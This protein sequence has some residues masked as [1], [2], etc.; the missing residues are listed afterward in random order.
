MSRIPSQYDPPRAASA[1]DLED[2]L[3]LVERVFR[4]SLDLG[5]TME[6]EF[7]L[8]F[9]PANAANLFIVRDGGRVVAHAGLLIRSIVA[10]PAC[11]P[12]SAGCIGAVCVDSDHRGRG[13][14]EAVTRAC[15][16]RARD[17][18]CHLALI[19]G[20][21]GIYARCGAGPVV[22]VRR[23]LVDRYKLDPPEAF[24][25]TIRLAAHSDIEPLCRLHQMDAPRYEWAPQPLGRLIEAAAHV[26]LRTWVAQRG[27]ELAA[28]LM[29]RPAPAVLQSRW[30]TAVLTQ[31]VG[32][33]ELFAPLAARALDA[34]RPKVLMVRRLPGQ[35]RL[36][37]QLT[38]FDHPVPAGAQMSALVLDGPGLLEAM[39]P[40]LAREP[41][42]AVQWQ[43]GGLCLRVQGDSIRL[44]DAPDVAAALFNGPSHW[45]RA[46]RQR[47][48]RAAMAALARILPVPI[49]DYGLD[50]I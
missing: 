26:G 11:R 41:E 19:S 31:F 32:R 29:I 37:P 17:A 43:G 33:V 40:R 18:G 44:A 49:P 39:A 23:F 45:P 14:G 15:I 2:L 4:T 10:D 5:P 25:G 46:M 16:A 1:D 21:G 22:P 42:A 9:S 36:E 6:L 20:V 24:A 50:Y 27:G 47:P 38:R 48:R 30:Q 35:A 28:G 34:M 8:L 3:E 12:L 13:L 7:P